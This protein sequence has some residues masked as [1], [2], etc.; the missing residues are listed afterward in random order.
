MITHRINNIRVIPQHIYNAIYEK[1]YQLD[2][3]FINAFDP[4]NG[5][6][7]SITYRR[8]TALNGLKFIGDSDGHKILKQIENI[9]KLFPEMPHL[10]RYGVSR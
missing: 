9:S 3:D 5:S 10:F 6:I 7:P 2:K 4:S 1:R 8:I